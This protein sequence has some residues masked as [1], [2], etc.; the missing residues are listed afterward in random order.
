M[1]TEKNGLPRIRSINI[2]PSCQS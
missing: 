2:N 1:N